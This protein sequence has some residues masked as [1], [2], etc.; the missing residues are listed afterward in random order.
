[1]KFFLIIFLLIPFM[2]FAE[3]K[4]LIFN[5][6]DD[7]INIRVGPIGK[8]IKT[9]YKGDFIFGINFS[10]NDS[11]AKW[12]NAFE[13]VIHSGQVKVVDKK[14]L[15]EYIQQVL[16]QEFQKIPSNEV[17][18]ELL[19][20]NPWIN[21]F[22]EKQFK[23]LDGR[24][25]YNILSY[26]DKVEG[27]MWIINLINRGEYSEALKNASLFGYTETVKW[28]L[29]NGAD[30]TPNYRQVIGENLGKENSIAVRDAI[31]YAVIGANNIDIIK[32]LIEHGAALNNKYI[33]NIRP[34]YLLI[35]ACKKGDINVLKL[36]VSNG[37]DV[38]IIEKNKSIYNPSPLQIAI[39]MNRL[40][41]VQLFADK[42]ININYPIVYPSN[43]PNLNELPKDYA[44]RLNYKEIYDYIFSKEEINDY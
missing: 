11:N 12:Y 17:K 35:N 25:Q 31:Y 2:S 30:C 7:Y 40:D 4:Y 29:K 27:V 43:T 26:N 9:V 39:E 34:E 38:N 10:I 32:L 44:W 41:M 3:S 13:G 8:I 1:M 21:N 23:N 14:A 20:D 22:T 5:S 36:L 33:D 6:S 28:L 15:L 37:A 42:G 18:K 24:S 16:P 19:A